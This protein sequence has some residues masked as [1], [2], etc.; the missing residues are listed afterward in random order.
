MILKIQK[1]MT[2]LNLRMNFLSKK[3]STKERNYKTKTFLW[4]AKFW[5]LK[6]KNLTRNSISNFLKAW[7]QMM[8][9][10]SKG[11]MIIFSLMILQTMYHHLKMILK[12]I[13]SLTLI[14]RTAHQTLQK[15]KKRSRNPIWTQNWC[16][17]RIQKW[18]HWQ[19]LTQINTIW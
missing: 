12:Q 19:I 5:N 10:W 16:S 2:P 6:S 3:Y 4:F 11:S 1:S 7:I 15:G 17:S 8:K 18:N 13:K 9:I 14:L